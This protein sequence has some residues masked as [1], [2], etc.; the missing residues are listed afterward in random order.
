MGQVVI[1]PYARGRATTVVTQQ[2]EQQHE[3]R[4]HECAREI[5][6]QWITSEG[7]GNSLLS[8]CREAGRHNNDY[9]L[10]KELD[11]DAIVA[12]EGPPQLER[13]QQH[14]AQGQRDATQACR[15][16]WGVPREGARLYSQLTALWHLPSKTR[17]DVLRCG[18]N[19][20]VLNKNI[21]QN[22]ACTCNIVYSM[23]KCSIEYI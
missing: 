13:R 14:I 7:D 9:A 18:L 2:C 5:Q 11:S 15:H 21:I 17:L 16:W 6:M 4:V 23:W 1:A 12:G 3:K 20:Y 10:A 19:G 8:G 22:G